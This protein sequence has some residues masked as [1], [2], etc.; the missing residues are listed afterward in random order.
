MAHTAHISLPMAV[1]INLNIMLGAG[2]FINTTEL[3]KH[4]GFL[5]GL[6]YIAVGILMFP[7]ILSIATLLRMHPAGGFY[8]F[9]RKEINAFAGFASAWSY[10]IG[11]LASATLMIHV[12]V[13]LLQ[14]IILPLASIP[15]LAIDAC[16]IAL[17]IGLNLL[18]VKTS[19]T[20]QTI[21][22]GFKTIPILGAIAIG[23]FMFKSANATA[24]HC[25]WE[26]IPIV[27]PLVLYATVGF[28]AACS[29]S[30]QIKDA[31]KNAARAVLISYGLVVIIAC[32]YQTLFYGALGLNLATLHDY[33][34]A[35]PALLAHL[36]PYASAAQ[37]IIITTLYLAIASS[38]LGGAYGIIFSNT[39]NLYTLAENNHVV[40]P[41]FFMQL[42]NHAIPWAC[43]LAE[44]IICALYLAVS[45]GAQLPLQQI[46]A[47]GCVLAYTM[48]V[49]SLAYAR[50]YRPQMHISWA[51][52]LCAFASCALL[53][54]ACIYSLLVNG[55]S[56]LILFTLLFAFGTAMFAQTKRRA[57]VS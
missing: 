10:F 21:F 16:C 28:E 34:G 49:L 54:G 44:G 24:A 12:S 19:Q 7:L 27:L 38:A 37:S 55:A 13:L 43:V 47:L 23:I 52:P 8:T 57:S 17:F 39:W 35:F 56:S 30:C 25:I 14:K 42:N 40:A 4:A 11:K 48:S 32:L 20:I 31:H 36:F 18:N 46:S 22:M 1:L 41:A 50:F 5:G 9:A 45:W 2:I 53:I 6:A 33:R 15:T 29:L 3:A 51:L 26:G